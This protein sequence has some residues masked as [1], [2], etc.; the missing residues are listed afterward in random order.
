MIELSNKLQL[1][2]KSFC[3]TKNGLVKTKVC[4]ILQI[5]GHDCSF[6]GHQNN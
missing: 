5:F 6:E 2:T 3:A 4:A 1:I